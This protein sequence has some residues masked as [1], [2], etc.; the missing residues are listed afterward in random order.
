MRDDARPA[1]RIAQIAF[2]LAL[3]AG[4]G[5]QW[6]VWD[7]RT[8]FTVLRW[9]AWSG[10]GVAA[11]ALVAAI[12]ARPGGSRRGFGIALVALV[13]GLIVFAVPWH[14]MRMA[15]SVPPLHDVTTDTENP[16]QF[17]DVLPLRK[18]ARNPP[19]HPGPR[20]AKMQRSAY[21]DIAPLRTQKSP[22]EAFD[23]ALGTAARMG[24]EI[25]GKDPRTGRIE[26]VDRT[27]WFGFQDDI[28]IRIAADG[29]GSRIDIRS[30]SRVGRS[31]AGANAKRVRAYLAALD[32][33][34]RK[35]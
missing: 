9:S 32:E 30:K 6:G 15:R 16:P 12:F 2:V 4:F 35:S 13:G 8:G 28:V 14:N 18:G 17:Q 1:S 19:E 5:T 27:F 11:I 33:Q 20:V 7:W 21:P 10:L 25:V 23:A 34:L 24:W 22:G 31:D 26:A 3:T 29:G